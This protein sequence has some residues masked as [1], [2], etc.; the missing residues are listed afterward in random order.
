MTCA[1]DCFVC[2]GAWRVSY[3]VWLLLIPWLLGLMVLVVLI[4]LCLLLIWLVRFGFGCVVCYAFVNLSLVV[5]FYWTHYLVVLVG[6]F[7]ACLVLDV[8]LAWCLVVGGLVGCCFPIW[9]CG[10]SVWFGLYCWLLAVFE[11]W[12]CGWFCG[13]C[14]LGVGFWGWYKT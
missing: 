1:L 12:F 10:L 3:D 6:L 7:F 5:Y 13:N 8:G 9:D 4:F 14:S 11:C 2:G